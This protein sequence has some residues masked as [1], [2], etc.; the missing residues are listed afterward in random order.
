VVDYVSITLAAVIGN[1]PVMNYEKAFYSWRA[2]ENNLGA[3]GQA[4][5]IKGGSATF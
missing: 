3:H 1:L 2:V 5:K 4:V